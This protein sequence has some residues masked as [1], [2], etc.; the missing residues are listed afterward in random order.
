MQARSNALGALPWV[1][2]LGLLL[3]GFVITATPAPPHPVPASAAFSNHVRLIFP[4]P[5]ADKWARLGNIG[6]AAPLA[7]AALQDDNPIV[8]PPGSLLAFFQRW[9]DSSWSTGLHES[10]YAYDL[11]ESVHV[12][13]LCLFFGLAVMFDFR[14]LGW[15]MRSIPVSEVSRRLLPWT[16]VGF[17][18]MVISGALLFSAIPLRSYMNIFFRTKMILLLLAGMNVWIFHTGVF[19]RVSSWDL[20]AKPP[21]PARVAGALSLV[22]WVGI[23]LS[24]RMIAYNWFDC[25][26]QPQPAIVNFLTSCIPPQPGR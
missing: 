24:G 3:C 17:I 21:R 15:S 16:I 5:A 20:A 14:L 13:A 18:I 22:L 12:W 23:V 25:D 7:A 26:R 11:I 2:I 1:A 19:R 8:A 10:R 4:G 6:A 9:G